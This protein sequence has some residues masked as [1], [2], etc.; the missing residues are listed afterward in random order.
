MNNGTFHKRLK[1]ITNALELSDFAVESLERFS[2]EIVALEIVEFYSKNTLSCL[3]H[4]SD[5]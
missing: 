3:N 4:K 2:G 5:R 1:W